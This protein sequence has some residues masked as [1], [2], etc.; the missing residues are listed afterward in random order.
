MRLGRRGSSVVMVM[1]FWNFPWTALV[2]M[3][4]GNSPD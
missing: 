1:D 3:E 4:K 2:A